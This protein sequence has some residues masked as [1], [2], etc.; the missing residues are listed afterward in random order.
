MTVTLQVTEVV[1]PIERFI[2]PLLLFELENEE[3]LKT[4]EKERTNAL[5]VAA[6][7]D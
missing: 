1:P 7:E 5:E 3:K 4:L 2:K 6:Q